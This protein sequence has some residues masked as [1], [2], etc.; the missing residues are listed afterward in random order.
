MQGP[1]RAFTGARVQQHVLPKDFMVSVIQSKFKLV[2]F[3]HMG[4]MFLESDVPPTPDDNR[5]HF[6]IALFFF[7]DD[8]LFPSSVF[9]FA[10]EARSAAGFS[11]SRLDNME[12]GPPGKNLP[13]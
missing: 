13:R 9:F 6:K 12:R 3:E 2:A 5:N 1:P 11:H 7:V 4:M 8:L 10:P